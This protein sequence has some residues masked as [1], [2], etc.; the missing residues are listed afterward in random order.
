MKDEH[1]HNKLSNLSKK[2]KEERSVPV[3]TLK[4]ETLTE[5]RKHKP[6]RSLTD[7][8][9]Q[10]K[11]SRCTC[12]LLFAV[13]ELSFAVL[14]TAILARAE[15]IRNELWNSGDVREAELVRRRAQ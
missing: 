9:P 5:R 15:A 13:L 14:V 11:A 12:L 8:G 2:A 1:V 4:L 3:P 6:G 10:T 7:R